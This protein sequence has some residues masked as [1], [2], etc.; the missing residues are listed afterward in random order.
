M[1]QAVQTQSPYVLYE[2]DSADEGEI[3]VFSE[4]DA[5]T[6][7]NMTVYKGQDFDEEE[8]VYH[9]KIWDEEGG[10]TKRKVDI[11]KIDSKNCDEVDMLTFSAHLSTSGQY[12][13]A[14]FKFVSAKVYA[15]KKKAACYQ[16]IFQK[17]DWRA[18]VRDFMQMQYEAGNVKGYLEYKKFLAFLE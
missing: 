4:V 10:M 11:A 8:P 7:T 12:V 6:G 17:T 9:V 5:R 3:R 1:N 16:D 15:Q 14:Y 18:I 13:Q 2:N